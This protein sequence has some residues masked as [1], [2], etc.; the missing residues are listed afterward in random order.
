MYLI[1]IIKYNTQNL[2]SE[3]VAGYL[4]ASER[5]PM[6][7]DQYVILARKKH[8]HVFHKVL[9]IVIGLTLKKTFMKSI[10]IY[11]L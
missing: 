5:L 11:L 7:A 1:I 6:T 4:K 10:N 9:N 2:E 3:G 8:L